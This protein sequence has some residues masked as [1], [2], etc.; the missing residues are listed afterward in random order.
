M[1]CNNSYGPVLSTSECASMDAAYPRCA[2]L[3]QSCYDN[4]NVWSCVPASL[5]CNNA[6]IGPYQRTGQNVYDVREKCEDSDN[7]CYPIL[8]SIQAYL[9]RKDVMD[10]VGAEVSNYESCNFNINRNFLF[11]GDW[12]KPYHYEVPKILERGISVFIYAGDAD[13]ICNWMG[14]QAWTEALE[15][16]GAKKF[17]AAATK[18]FKVNKNVQSAGVY[19]T[20]EGLTFMRVYGAGHMVPYNQPENSLAMFNSW[21][22]QEL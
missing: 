1:A 10:A 6:M 11:A 4:E 17:R 18:D 15:W 5:Y 16:P 14:N 20:A 7:L 12:F 8:G 9:N 22:S 13:F 21:L 2:Q 19:K 3:I